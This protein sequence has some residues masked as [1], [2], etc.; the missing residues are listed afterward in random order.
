MEHLLDGQH[1]RRAAAA[2]GGGFADG[3]GEF[4]GNDEHG[5]AP[6][7]VRFRWSGIT[8]NGARWEQAFSV[9]RGETW[10]T[11]WIMTFTRTGSR[12]EEARMTAIN[13]H[14][15]LDDL[16]NVPMAY[17][18]EWRVAEPRAALVLPGTVFKWYHVHR[19]G[20]PVPAEM[21][22]EA[23]EVIASAIADGDWRP[24]YGLNFA[25]I[26]VSTTHAFLI[27]GIWRGHQEL[28]ERMYDKRPR[29]PARSR[30]LQ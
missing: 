24:E 9:D 2:G 12:E 13:N 6:I 23:R 30:E 25:L 26:H 18:H 3:V 29:R 14:F 7:L 16:G 15:T 10:E 21:D 1:E 11:N 5:A 20:V 22:V 28:W 17:I 8:A 19:V 27:A 4:F